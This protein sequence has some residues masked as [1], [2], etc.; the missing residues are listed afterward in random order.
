MGHNIDLANPQPEQIDIVD[1]AHHMS[2][3]NRYNGACPFPYSV[4]QHSILVASILPDELKL[5]GLLHDAAEAYTG[6]KIRP[7]KILCPDDK[8]L[9]DKVQRVICEKFGLP[10]PEPAEVKEADNAVY[11]MEKYHLMFWRDLVED[12]P[13]SV[14]NMRVD[15]M[16][17]E[18]VKEEFL[19][20]Y[21][22][23]VYGTRDIR[24]ESGEIFFSGPASAAYRELRKMFGMSP[25]MEAMN[26]GIVPGFRVPV[27]KWD[28]KAA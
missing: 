27:L 10:W 11:A 5:W 13:E 7:A 22:Q 19:A 26:T 9:E 2:Q 28:G 20:A 16:H 3:I 17:W 15:P 4:A 24:F 8:T 25:T 6:D 12:I 21:F 1:I 23:Y 18:S 14:R